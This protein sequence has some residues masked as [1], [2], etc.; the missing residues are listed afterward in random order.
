MEGERYEA[1]VP[2][3]LDLQERAELVINALTRCTNPESNYDVYFY[4][5]LRRNPPVMYRLMSFY[6]KFWEGLA[7]MRYVTGSSFNDY[8]D[9]RWREV[10]LGW[11]QGNPV[12]QGA[13][14]GRIL[15]WIANNYRH[16]KNACWQEVGE[17]AIKVLS[18]ALTHDKDF[19]YFTDDKGNMHAGWEA[20]YQGW[21]LQGATRMYSIMDSPSSKKLATE[22]ARYLKDYAQIFDRDS[23][24][25]ARHPSDLGP[26]LHFHHNGNTMVGISEYA[27][28]TGDEEFADF[29]RKGYEYALYVGS[30]LVGFFPEYINDWPDPRPFIDCETCCTVDMIMLGINLSKLGQGDYWD[31]VDRYVRNQFIE[32]QMRNGDWIYQIAA[33]NPSVP[34]G[35]DEDEDQ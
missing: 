31:D 26:A 33:K 29:A 19:C 16:E 14:G 28:A 2:D 24:F 7:L 12:L 22:L 9:Q 8:V 13:D 18:E 35:P 17:Q 15:C 6:G 20:T 4:G 10:F 32:M 11:F 3:T 21:T 23:R 34:V 30:P 27:L 1:E 25:Q 5:D